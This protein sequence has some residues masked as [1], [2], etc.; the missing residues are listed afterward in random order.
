MQPLTEKPPP[1][2]DRPRAP[3]RACRDMCGCLGLFRRDE[4]RRRQAYRRG[5]VDSADALA[6]SLYLTFESPVYMVV[7]RALEQAVMLP[8]GAGR[9]VLRY[10]H[11]VG[12]APSP[13]FFFLPRPG[14]VGGRRPHHRDDGLYAVY[15][16]R[17][18]AGGCV[19]RH[20]VQGRAK[21]SWRITVRSTAADQLATLQSRRPGHVLGAMATSDSR[22]R[23]AAA[24]SGA[25]VLGYGRSISPCRSHLGGDPMTWIAA[26]APSLSCRMAADPCASDRAIGGPDRPRTDS[27]PQ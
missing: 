9:M 26:F 1:L 4:A 19:G 27:H 5:F 3:A 11:S 13:L 21:A 15:T 23:G 7:S 8:P 25:R 2:C 18:R 20:S 6:V 16:G 14:L 17:V 22:C 24:L 12:V 10:R